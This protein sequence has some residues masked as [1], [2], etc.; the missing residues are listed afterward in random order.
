ML[1]TATEEE[2]GGNSVFTAGGFRFTHAGL[3]DLRTD[4]LTGLSEQEAPQIDM[5]PLPAETYLQRS[6]ERH[7]RPA[8]P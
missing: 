2:H 1:E 3:D 5:P 7:Q 8:E 6:H 4:V